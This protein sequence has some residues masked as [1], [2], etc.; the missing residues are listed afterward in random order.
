MEP[1]IIIFSF[2]SVLLSLLLNK[3]AISMQYK[4]Y[5]EITPLERKVDYFLKISTD[6]EYAKDIRMHSGGDFEH[7]SEL[8]HGRHTPR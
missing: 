6:R 5:E 2:A 4:F 1:I 3:K 7:P 8:L